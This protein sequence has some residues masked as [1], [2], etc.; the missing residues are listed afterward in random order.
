MYA[1]AFYRHAAGITSWRHNTASA[2]HP[3]WRHALQ[4]LR[5]TTHHTNHNSD[6]SVKCMQVKKA[7]THDGSETPMLATYTSK[8]KLI[9]NSCTPPHRILGCG[10]KV[11]IITTLERCFTEL[12]FIYEK[13]HQ[14]LAGEK[15]K[16]RLLLLQN[17]TEV[18]CK[19][20]YL[21]RS[22]KNLPVFQVK[23]PQTPK[24]HHI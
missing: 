10:I 23:K 2:M 7:L 9:C 24:P 21:T 22:E 18:P 19:G 1:I 17:R 12:H 14:H 15:K 5:H 13:T 20:E 3:R 11:R 6:H 16:C 8:F 4:R